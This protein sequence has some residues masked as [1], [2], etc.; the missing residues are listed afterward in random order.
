MKGLVNYIVSWIM[1]L[2][3]HYDHTIGKWIDNYQSYRIYRKLKRS[4]YAILS[5]MLEYE[6]TG[7]DTKALLEMLRDNKV[8]VRRFRHE[9]YYT[10][11]LG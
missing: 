11:K 9:K 4:E 5:L 2:N 1:V 7:Q 10:K 3:Y 6:E 8:R